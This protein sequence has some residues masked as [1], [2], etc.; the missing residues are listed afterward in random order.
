MSRRRGSG[1]QTVGT[2]ITP[3]RLRYSV[4]NT[5]KRIGSSKKKATWLFGWRGEEKGHSVEYVHSLIT[6]K[7]ILI[8]DGRVVTTNTSVLSFEFSH[9]W[10][11]NGHIFRVEA[12]MGSVL[13]PPSSFLLMVKAMTPF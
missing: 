13:V 2:K 10:G 3:H 6:G 9:G 7:R 5:G 4:T 8:E 12:Q 11:S 1:T